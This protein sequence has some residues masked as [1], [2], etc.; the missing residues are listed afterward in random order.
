MK[1]SSTRT[2]NG[3]TLALLCGTVSRRQPIS[4]RSKAT[5]AGRTIYFQ[6]MALIMTTFILPAWS[7][8]FLTLS[9]QRYATT[10]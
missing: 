7:L 10:V 4:L 8:A 9:T 5:F 2:S 6:T 1:E 3:V